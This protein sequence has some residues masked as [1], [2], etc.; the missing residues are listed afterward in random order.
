MLFFQ[1]TNPAQAALKSY[2]NPNLLS[3]CFGSEKARQQKAVEAI[4]HNSLSKVD[5]PLLFEALK[6]LE[7]A[8][9]KEIS[10]KKILTNY[11]TIGA[12][13]TPTKK[14]HGIWL[15][16]FQKPEYKKR[17]EKIA[18]VLANIDTVY[19]NDKNITDYLSPKEI[20]GLKPEQRLEVVR[21]LLK[22]DAGKVDSFLA[23]TVAKDRRA[24][25]IKQ[26][27]ALNG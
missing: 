20:E 25:I 21:K 9:E 3:S 1:P 12:I 10:T 24:E 23:F 14:T 5:A 17:E 22:V 19:A 27:R 26:A 6:K 15:L 4:K 11:K 13:A 2:V 8:G 18:W 16:N 7:K